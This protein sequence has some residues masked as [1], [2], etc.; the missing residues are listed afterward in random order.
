MLS[1][2]LLAHVGCPGPCEAGYV[3]SPLPTPNVLLE[4][5]RPEAWAGVFTR[6]RPYETYETSYKRIG[7][8]IAAASGAEAISTP[9]QSSEHAPQGCWEVCSWYQPGLYQCRFRKAI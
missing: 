9:K 1:L 8:L 5:A 6:L 4:Y 7:R 3:P 2:G